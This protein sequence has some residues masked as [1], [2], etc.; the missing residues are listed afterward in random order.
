MK[1]V[2][3][4][5]FVLAS[6]VGAA[7][8]YVDWA[9]TA[10][11]DAANRG[12]SVFTVPKGATLNQVGRQLVAAGFVRSELA[13]KLWLKLRGN[14]P[15]PKA[16]KHEITR[17]MNLPDL[18]LALAGTPL[19]EDVP[20]TMREGWRLRDSD[21]FLASQGL[22]KPG[23]YIAAASNPAG[24]TLRFELDAAARDLCGYLFPETYRVPPGKL[25][26]AALVQRQLDA[27][28][29][30]FVV[31]Y[32]AQITASDRTLGTIV[33]MAS[34]LEREETKLELRPKVAGVLY[35]R[36]DHGMPLGV[37][38]TSRF[39]LEDWND[40]QAFL[41]MLR[42]KDAPYNTRHRSG[43]PPGPI[44]TPG[45]ASLV[46]ALMPEPTE[47]WY[48]LHDKSANIHFARSLK[49]HEANRRK[50]GVW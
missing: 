21:A 47:Y 1:T 45:L 5:A 17:A 22:I 39:T 34:L 2:G 24:F 18:L 6:G 27:F 29:A 46:A 31:P 10:P 25:D 15:L 44:G 3:V 28:H 35:K 26:V 16:G 11:I 13:F 12:P 36:L 7:F 37:D 4:L 30:R 42:D 49:E 23:E 43:P 9:A 41:T 50:Y 38:A 19:S 40:R 20:I 8:F 33:I 32:Q 48:Y 14:A